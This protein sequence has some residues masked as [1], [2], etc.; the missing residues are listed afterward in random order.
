MYCYERT[1]RKVALRDN[2]CIF[3]DTRKTINNKYSDNN[4]HL[5]FPFGDRRR[6]I[7]DV[8]LS[9][10]VKVQQCSTKQMWFILFPHITS[11]RLTAHY[12]LWRAATT[13]RWRQKGDHINWP[14]I[15]LDAPLLC[16]VHV[17]YGV[18]MLLFSEIIETYLRLRVAL[19]MRAYST[20]TLLNTIL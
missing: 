13:W 2:S 18:I 4:V 5:I 14:I 19:L 15:S 12:Y 20:V 10:W 16:S 8:H 9:S 7:Y 17:L 3:K 11:S 1:Q 6:L